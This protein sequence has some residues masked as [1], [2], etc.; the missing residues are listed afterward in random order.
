MDYRVSV[1]G[2][3]KT[4]YANM[5]RQ[6]VERDMNK[7]IISTCCIAACI[8]ED[9]ANDG[10]T[11]SEGN[12]RVLP[13]QSEAIEGIDNIYISDQLDNEER[14]EMITLAS[15]FAQVLTDLPGRTNLTE[16][17]SNYYR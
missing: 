6:Y 9:E 7:A 3:I 2:T 17:N 12:E 1:E 14:L 8:I 5:L 10:G 11:Y 4:F 16:P 13:P 15:A